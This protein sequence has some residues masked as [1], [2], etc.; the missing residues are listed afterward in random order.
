MWGLSRLAFRPNDRFLTAAAEAAA[1]LNAADRLND[2][3]V[4]EGIV[5]PA[6]HTNRTFTLLCVNS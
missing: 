1:R 2:T 5:A 3:D 6:V 4:S